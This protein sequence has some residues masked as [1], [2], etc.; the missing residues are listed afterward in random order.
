M[1]RA[2]AAN[3]RLVYDTKLRRPGCVL[4]QAA[5]GCDWTMLD[6]LGFQPREWLTAPTPDMRRLTGTREEWEE[7]LRR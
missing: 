5:A 3:I 1:T 6:E 2:Q 7:L 4:L